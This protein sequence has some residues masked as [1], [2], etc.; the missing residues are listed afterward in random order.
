MKLHYWITAIVLISVNAIAFGQAPTT[1]PAWNE[2]IRKVGPELTEADQPAVSKFLAKNASIDPFAGDHPGSFSD[3]HKMIKG[4][5]IISARAYVRVP[6]T[7]ATDLATDVADA[8]VIPE[9]IRKDL[10]VSEEASAEANRTAQKWLK[11]VLQAAD[12]QSV[13]VLLVWQER[14]GDKRRL[15]GGSLVWVLMAGD[16]A[17]KITRIIYG[18]PRATTTRPSE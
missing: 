9:P 1:R 14:E 10:H 15:D 16:D 11:Q 18:N 7:L 12:D 17:G 13:G 4:S 8:K 5:S 2:T 3:L 6:E